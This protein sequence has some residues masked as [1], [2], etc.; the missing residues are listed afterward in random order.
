[1]RLNRP[2][3]PATGNPYDRFDEGRSGHLGTDNCGRL[4]LRFHFAYST[5]LRASLRDES[6]GIPRAREA[7]GEN[8][9]TPDP[10]TG[11]QIP[12]QPLGEGRSGIPPGCDGKLSSNRGSRCASTPGYRL[13]SL[14][15]EPR[16]PG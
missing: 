12:A 3:E 4:K 6:E 16:G 15:D 13:S 7:L 8:V 11:C 9:Q 5:T 14:R 1:M 10:G 2:G